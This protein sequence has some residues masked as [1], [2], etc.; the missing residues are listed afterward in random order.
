MRDESKRPNRLIRES[1]PYLQQHAFNPVDWFPWGEEAFAEARREGKPIFLSIGYSTCHWCHVMERESFENDEVAFLL[2]EAFVPIKVDREER[3][4]VDRTYMTALQAMGQQG[5]WPMSLFLTPELI[6]FYGGTYFPPTARYGRAGFPDILRR[7]HHIWANERDKVEESTQ[8]VT[9]FLRDAA[10]AGGGEAA[11]EEELFD[12]CF[13]QMASTYDAENGGFGT[14]AKFPRPS[15][16]MFLLRYHHRFGNPDALEMTSHT[17]AMMAAG[18]VYDQIGGGFHR[19]AV[20]P[21]WRVP[22]FEKM[23]YDQAQLVQ[24]CLDVFQISGDDGCVATAC[25]TLDY[26]LRDMTDREG[27]FYSAEDADSPMP[28]DRRT[29]GEGAFYLWSK[30]EVVALSGNDAEMVCHFYGIEAEGNVPVDPQQEFTGRNILYRP[31]RVEET[32]ARFSRTEEEVVQRMNEATRIL[33][34]AREK[35]P[36]PFKDDKVLTSWN[37]LMIGAFARASRVLRSARY[38]EA[39]MRGAGFILRHLVDPESGGLLHRYRGGA[40]GVRGQLS[41]YAFFVSG[42][43]D[44]YEAT[45]SPE[46]LEEAV[47]LTEVQ[48]ALFSDPEGG[49]FFETPDGE[50]VLLARMKEQYD[51][52]EPTGNSVAAMNLV[53]LSRMIARPAWEQMAR[54]TLA[55]A[56]GSL[57]RHPYA[58]PYAAAVCTDL[59]R[60]AEQIVIAGAPGRQDALELLQV[61]SRHFMPGSVV[62][63]SDGFS[64]GSKLE[65][66]NPLLRSLRQIDGRATAYVCRDFQ[67]D[68][69]VSD[70]ALLEQLFMRTDGMR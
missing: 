40:A 17:L 13:N 14:G 35:R 1:S 47:R 36:R 69:P 27:G 64:H 34:A 55:G 45:G 46:W 61:V 33:F 70:P 65:E 5:G 51:G 30:E 31:W 29:L 3:P 41:D 2:N 20:D 56:L 19:Y 57:H 54:D 50:P 23:L 53:R 38:K 26:V 39:A 52:A 32:A 37:G 9:A 18:G 16:F 48:I 28:E 66:W 68:L 6:P 12:R 24:T 15:V 25:G 11:F 62:M 58:V 43:I 63:F 67:C 7:I 44:L 60:P 22:H 49:G 21:R 59:E 10:A 8:G 42:L 4:D